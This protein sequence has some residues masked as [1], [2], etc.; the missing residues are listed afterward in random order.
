MIFGLNKYHKTTAVNFLL[1]LLLL[2][3]GFSQIE[4]GGIKPSDLFILSLFFMLIIKGKIKMPILCFFFIISFIYAWIIGGMENYMVLVTNT[5]LFLILF[6]LIPYLKNIALVETNLYL[7]YLN[8]SMFLT[9]LLSLSILFLFPQLVELVADVSSGG[10]RLKGFFTQTNGYAFV[11]LITFPLA[12]YFLN[13]SKTLFNY[14]NV[15]IFLISILLTQSRGVIFSLIIAFGI[16][17]LIYLTRSKK[18]RK[19]ILPTLLV[20]FLIGAIFSLIPVYLQNTFGIN[21]SRLNPNTSSSSERNLNEISIESLEDDRL[22]LV[23]S[24]LSTIAEYPLGLG[25]QDH[26]IKIGEITG[27]YLVP[28][29]YFLTIILTYGIILGTIWLIIIA[30]LLSAGLLR[31]YFLKTNPGDPEF[32]LTIV[33]VSLSFFYLTHSSEWSYL[34]ILIAL[35]LALTNKKQKSYRSI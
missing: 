20:T 32:Y 3:A 6:S 7:S 4:V 33:L 28:H 1:S 26:H 9:N 21:L 5:I 8:Y 29:N 24:A 14:A 34:Y 30:K 17:Y 15:G 13:R 11:L 27:V 19:F 31:L 12:V 2:V 18:I 10:I 25:Y 35:Y 23:K 16:V 22:Y